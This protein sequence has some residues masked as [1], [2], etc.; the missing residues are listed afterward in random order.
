MEGL[1]TSC[2]LGLA[3]DGNFAVP[4]AGQM[5]AH[6]GLGALADFDLN[7]VGVLKVLVGDAIEVGD[8][9]K[10]I[11]EGLRPLFRQDAALAAAHGGLRQGAAPAEGHPGLLERAPKLIWE[12]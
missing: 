11:P 2:P 8:V 1:I 3:S 12:M 5:A 4:A 10:D 6:A 7:G 9:L